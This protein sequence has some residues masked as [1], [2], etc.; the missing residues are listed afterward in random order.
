MKALKE[1]LEGISGPELKT[2]VEHDGWDHALGKIGANLNDLRLL[3][4]EDPQAWEQFKDS[5]LKARMNVSQDAR[6]ETPQ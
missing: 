3:Q 1:R 4:E 5:Q 6:I 2:L